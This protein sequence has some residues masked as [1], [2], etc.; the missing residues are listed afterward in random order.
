M[1]VC[2]FKAL[3]HSMSSLS[4]SMLLLMDY[5]RREGGEDGE[6]VMY[7]YVCVYVYMTYCVLHFLLFMELK[8]ILLFLTPD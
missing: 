8:C 1:C 3:F 2:V 7:I 5:D 6:S 4:V